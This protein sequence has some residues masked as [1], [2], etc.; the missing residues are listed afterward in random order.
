MAAVPGS[1][2][3]SVP[4]SVPVASRS[5]PAPV[6]RSPAPFVQRFTSGPATSPRPTIRSPKAPVKVPAFVDGCDHNYGTPTQCVPLIFPAGVTDKC[7][8]LAAHGFTALIVA[9]RDS[10]RLDADGDGTACN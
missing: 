3:E 6:V 2:P 10:Q 9:G 8:W 1:V 7:S 4:G 5:A